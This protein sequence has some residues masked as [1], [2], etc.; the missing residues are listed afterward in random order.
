MD[1]VI[2][3]QFEVIKIVLTSCF[4]TNEVLS[5]LYDYS[6]GNTRVQ[7][8]ILSYAC[9]LYLDPFSS[10]ENQGILS[11]LLSEKIVGVHLTSIILANAHLRE[12][13]PILLH[14]N[15]KTL[16][17]QNNLLDAFPPLKDDVDL[18]SLEILNISS[19]NFVELPVEIFKLP[20]LTRLIASD[21]KIKSVP[22][23]MWRAPVLK[24]LNLS[25]NQIQVLPYHHPLASVD[26]VPYDGRHSTSLS[27]QQQ[28][29]S[30]RVLFNKKVSLDSV[31][32]SYI[33]YDIVCSHN[34]HRGQVGFSLQTLDLSGNQLIELPRSLPCLTPLLN[35]LKV[36]KNNLTNLG[37]ASDYPPCLQ[38]LDAQ[39]NG[40]T[41]GISPS[42]EPPNITCVQSQV[43][44][45][46]VLCSHARHQNLANLKFLYLSGNRLE[47]LQIEFQL[48]DV[49]NSYNETQA[50]LNPRSDLLFPCL[51]GLRISNNRLIK[52]PD[53]IHRL[54]TLCE[55]SFDGN[56]RIE[57]LPNSLH[58]LSKLFTLK[59]E[60]ISDPVVQELANLKN[61]PEILYYLKALECQ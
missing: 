17:V 37:Q 12:L 23:D 53:N 34:L 21:N 4:S 14:S 45:A 47:E 13:P 41:V 28:R 43:S 49:D 40:I 58:R 30:S 52:L 51:Q 25:G 38:T 18:S 19:N 24:N 48:P 27:M 8:T 22:V 5:K 16:D 59:Y 3:R 20:L 36:S 56:R 7:D 54:D 11:S 57:R 44:H 6:S 33:N 60:G 31:R 42:L 61:A 15:L 39:N 10:L 50:S 46:P 2:N 29:F 35:T 9:K 55:L 32:R 1:A 26:F